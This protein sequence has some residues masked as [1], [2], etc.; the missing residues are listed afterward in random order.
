[1]KVLYSATP[2]NKPIPISTGGGHQFVLLWF[3]DQLDW[4]VYFCDTSVSK[5]YIHKIIN[6]SFT[7]SNDLFNGLNLCQLTNEEYDLY[8]SWIKN[9]YNYQDLHKGEEIN[10]YNKNG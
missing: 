5:T 6:K 4:F 9:N 8:E 1:M 7:N 10:D 3:E 2:T